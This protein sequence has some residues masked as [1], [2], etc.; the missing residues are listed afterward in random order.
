VSKKETTMKSRNIDTL[1]SKSSIIFP[2]LAAFAMGYSV[3]GAGTVTDCTQADLERALSGG[4]KVLFA[5]SGTL[6][7]TNTLSI[8]DHTDIEANGYDITLSGGG[9]VRLFQV[10]TNVN[11]A[12]HGV[13][14]AGGQVVPPDSPDAN[15]SIPGL[16]GFG[17][18]ILNLGG[19]I[20][21]TSCTL[22]NH[23]V[24]GGNGGQNPAPMTY[25]TGHGGKGYGAAICS[26]GGQVSLT[27][28]VLTGNLAR[29]GIGSVGYPIGNAGTA[30]GGAIYASGGTVS[31]D[32]VIFSTNQAIGG[33]PRN[34]G[35]EYG[36]SGSAFGGAVAAENSIL[37]VNDSVF[38]GNSASGAMM[39][40]ALD[41]GPGLGAAFGGAVSF[42]TGSLGVVTLCVFT[43]N[44][45]Q[46]GGRGRL[47]PGGPATGGA[48]YNL[49]NLT[50]SDSVFSGNGVIGGT[51]K[52]PGAAH[53]GAIGS[54]NTL[55][56]TGCTFNEN[57]ARTGDAGDDP[58]PI[59]ASSGGALWVSGG[60]VITNSTCVANRAV[61]ATR[62]ANTYLGGG[63]ASGGAL[64][65][66][67]G[68]AQLV[69]VTL[70]DNQA[71]GGAG[72]YPNLEGDAYGGGICNSY[73][74]LFVLN[75][76]IANSGAS[77]DVWGTLTDGGYNICSDDTAQWTSITSRESTDPL[78]S[79]L[80]FNGGPVATIQLLA[81]SPARDAIPN[82]FP[83]VDQRGISRPQGPAADIGAYE[84]D[85]F[86]STP[87]IVTQPQGTSARAGTSTQFT[88]VAAGT[89]TLYFQWHKDGNPIAG[90]TMSTLPLNAVGALDAGAYSVIVSNSLGVTPS[91]AAVLVVDSTP[92]LLSQPQS[93]V[94]SP[95]GTVLFSVA[96]DGPA[97]A[98]QWSHHGVPVP[99]MTGSAYP[100]ESASAGAQGNYFVAV[101][102]FAGAVTSSVATLTFD[103]SALSILSQPKDKAVEPG[104]PAT[105]TVLASGI[106]VMAYQWSH[107]GSPIAGATDAS[108]TVISADPDAVGGY[109]VL[110]TNG[111][112]AA[113]SATAYLALLDGAARPQ[114]TLGGSPGN[115]LSI[116]FS[117]A[118]GRRYRLLSSTDLVT[119]SAVDTNTA[120]TAGPLQFI[121][122]NPTAPR[123]F[124][125]V[126]TP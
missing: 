46:G 24:R 69:N 122:P 72:S 101:T 108:F 104:Y 67:D 125:R 120:V 17:A 117:A 98:Y 119:W 95:G 79:A 55:A 32:G 123:L 1:G 75:S 111:Y 71:E 29:G 81:G 65:L 80:S 105:F 12:I 4:G 61:G 48:V 100:I 50:I 62:V 116:T 73:G 110:V 26:L 7:L 121:R 13:V 16:D 86:A 15:P 102:N 40:I 31:L 9:A 43:N 99:G 87:T 126:A 113:T 38:S 103:A 124:Y 84:A 82:G 47:N 6:T 2:L 45:A 89:P 114:L 66:A 60:L 64:F 41:S 54:S 19:T 118:A 74:M 52:R 49:G 37:H 83:P 30:S 106:P 10:A 44:L 23:Y 28:C 115:F 18:G 90:A 42:S 39:S 93:V 91:H 51:S 78:L 3:F 97:L 36:A 35:V 53:G 96:A 76:I 70:A 77:G 56:L 112:A 57:L 20:H 63:A 11:L 109:S 58:T 88:V 94:A 34:T 59:P 21:L 68:V 92:L 85:Y 14:L 33:E 5:C 25:N 8:V 107:N 27:N 22:S